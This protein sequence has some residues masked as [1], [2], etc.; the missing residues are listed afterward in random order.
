MADFIVDAANFY[1]L[2]QMNGTSGLQLLQ[3]LID[4]G[5]KIVITDAVEAEIAFP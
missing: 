5:H 1:T 2:A 3:A 4:A